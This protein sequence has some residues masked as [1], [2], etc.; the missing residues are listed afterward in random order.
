MEVKITKQII[1]WDA[2]KGEM[3]IIN[4]GEVV[5]LTD[6]QAKLYKGHFEDASQ[7]AELN[8]LRA[9]YADL[10][11]KAADNRWSAETLI[12]RI[13]ELKVDDASVGDEGDAPAD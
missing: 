7:D 12:K 3:L 8:A 4:A 1:G 11:G 5:T 6:A 13:A 9:E 2:D 10:A